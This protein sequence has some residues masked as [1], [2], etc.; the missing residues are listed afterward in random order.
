V[1]LEG[2]TFAEAKA[3]RAEMSSHSGKLIKTGETHF[4]A[5]GGTQSNR[6]KVRLTAAEHE[7]LVAQRGET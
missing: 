5:I 6:H 4:V 7:R 2:L 3:D 1:K